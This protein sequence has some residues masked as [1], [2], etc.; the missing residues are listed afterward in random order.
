MARLPAIHLTQLK[1]ALR[2]IG[3]KLHQMLKGGQRIMPMSGGNER[4]DQSA[5]HLNVI[6]IGAKSLTKEPRCLLVMS[7]SSFCSCLLQRRTL[8][9]T[10][11]SWRNEQASESKKT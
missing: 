10:F 9:H 2:I 4:I 3:L 6:G 8:R 5:E 7:L 11:R 1:N